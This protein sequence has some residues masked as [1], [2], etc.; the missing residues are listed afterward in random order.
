MQPRAALS[1]AER[2]PSKPPKLGVYSG[3]MLLFVIVSINAIL[4]NPKQPRATPGVESH[5]R[6]GGVTVEKCIYPFDRE[7]CY[8]FVQIVGMVMK[9]Y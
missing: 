5:P 4:S 9:M 8:D 3:L 2:T 7:L 6:L 1:N